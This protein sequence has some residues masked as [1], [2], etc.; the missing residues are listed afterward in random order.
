MLNHIRSSTYMRS[1]DDH[2]A[3]LST[4]TIGCRL[5]NI[6]HPHGPS[7]LFLTY[8]H[9]YTAYGALRLAVLGSNELS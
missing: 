4:G 3:Q 2:G 5:W 1:G 6:N 7:L 9:L 8:F